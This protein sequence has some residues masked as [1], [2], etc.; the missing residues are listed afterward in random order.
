MAYSL[1]DIKHIR[2][3]G[4]WQSKSGGMLNVLFA[5]SETETHTFLG[6]D[7]PEFERIKEISGVNIKG[8]RSYAVSNIAMGSV[9]A[10]EWHRARSEYLFAPKGGADIVCVDFDGNE[11]SFHVSSEEAIIIPPMILHTYTAT[12][13]NTTL[14]VI[15]N[16]LFI[17]EKPETHDS[18]LSDEF[19]EHLN[20]K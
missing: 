5:L 16:T 7:N 3:Q 19:Y 8:L 13:D 20:T 1:K 18:Y 11:A 4:P 15:C 17:P 6:Y 2:A 9:G 10:K 12:E 14:Q